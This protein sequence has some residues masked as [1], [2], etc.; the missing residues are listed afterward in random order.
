MKISFSTLAC[1]SATMRQVVRM[2]SGEGYDG[3]EL[4]F[5]ENEDSFWKLAAFSGEGLAATK[6][7]LIDQGLMISCVDTSCRFHWPDATERE[8]WIDEG[9]RMSDLAADLGAPGIRVFGDTIQAGADRP[10][11]RAWIAE[12]IHKLAEIAGQKSVEV[13]LES[14]GDF[15]TAAETRSLLT[16]A[17]SQNIGAVWDP[18]NSFVAADER[19]AEGA[20]ILGALIRHVHVKD[21]RRDTAGFRYVLTGDGEFPLRELNSS[22]RELHY[23]RF[24]SFEWE[25]KWHPELDDAEIAL[26]HFAKWFRENV[27]MT[28][29]LQ[30]GILRALRTTDVPAAFELSA[31]AGWNQTQEDWQMLLTLAAEGCMA[32]E[33]DGVLAAT[34]TLLCYG[35]QLAWIGM[36]LTKPEFQRRGLAKK[37]F[38]EALAR[39]DSMGVAA[40]KLDATD[41]GQPLYEKFGFRA[42][43]EIERWSR[44]SSA[45][46]SIPVEQP[47]AGP[48][49]G[50]CFDAF[51]A[52]RSALLDHLAR[53]RAPLVGGQSYVFSRPGRFS[54]YLGPCF[55]G[56]PRLARNLISRSCREHLVQLGVGSVSQQSR[57]CF[58]R[59]RSG[60]HT[61]KAP[62]ANVARKGIA[63][64]HKR[65]LR[66]RW[67]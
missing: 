50:S 14:H 44:P 48:W 60:I 11:T 36:V 40:I 32:I 20:E 45:P 2:A 66:D 56:D 31:G 17:D 58:N 52:D 5:V 22:L 4:R 61:E 16:D 8:R 1:P 54:E 47:P 59:S 19:P 55:G 9:E 41:Q 15:C 29:A 24:L 49:N 33:I 35:R 13:W 10:S 3:I 28:D 23:A 65:D 25:K 37:L 30:T 6:Q 46:A 26:P 21:V 57:G 67:I 62:A 12:S 34:T 42:E 64:K 63:E 18:V 51:E 53:R 43:R 7:L 39:A 27:E 38:Q